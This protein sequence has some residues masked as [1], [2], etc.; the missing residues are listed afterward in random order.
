MMQG[1]ILILF[2]FTR[3]FAPGY[4][5][6]ALTGLKNVKFNVPTPTVNIPL[7]GN[8]IDVFQLPLCNSFAE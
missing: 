8:I 6:F 2:H 7:I 5:Y 1:V 3:D 4:R